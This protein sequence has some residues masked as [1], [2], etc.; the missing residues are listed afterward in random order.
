M[1]PRV[2][3]VSYLEKNNKRYRKPNEDFL[4]LSADKRFA[5]VADGCTRTRIDGIYPAISAQIASQCFCELAVSAYEDGVHDLK[6]IFRHGN[7]GIRIENEKLGIID[8][9]ELIGCVAVA[10]YFHNFHPDIFYYA[11]IGD[12]GILIYD[13]DL[14]PVF[15][16]RN[17]LRTL[18]LFRDRWGLDSEERMA[19]WRN[20]MR[21]KPCKE[22]RLTHGGLTGEKNALHYGH[23]GYRIVEPGDTVLL[24]TDGILPFVFDMTFRRII[25]KCLL[26][27]VRDIALVMA[28][29]IKNRIPKLA[30]EGEKNLDDDKAFVA[31][32]YDE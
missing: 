13:R 23:S 31:F 16:S 25:Q 22:R 3:M 4:A 24:F 19:L 11:Y 2:R 7:H 30:K 29:Y 8:P 10:G 20:E 32:S 26:L 15:L 17:Q 6:A 21:N 14:F 9:Y 12:C 18:E 5:A 27:A 28:P 1:M